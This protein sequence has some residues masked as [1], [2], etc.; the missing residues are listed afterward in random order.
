M[1]K[2]E[3]AGSYVALITPF[4]DNDEVDYAKIEELVEWH[5]AEGT[6]GIVPCGTT[7]ESPTLTEEE[8]KKVIETVVKKANKRCH[9]VA[10]AGG[11]CTKKVVAFT[12]WCKEIGAD[13]VLSVI[14][15][16]NK[17]TQ[18]GLY[19]HFKAVADVGIPV[20]LYN[21]PGRCGGG[22]LT[23]ATIAKLYNDCPT[24]CAVKEATGSV[25]FSSEISSVCGIQ[26]FSGD[27]SLTVPLMSI[28]AKGV[29][30]VAANLTPRK[31]ADLC[32]AMKDGDLKKAQQLHSELYK[33]CKAMFCETNPI[34]CK[35]AGA[36]MGKWKNNTRLPMTPMKAENE[37]QLKAALQ[38]A[39][40]L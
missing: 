21:I 5:I 11:N 4:T 9:V 36:M 22:G 23:S 25:D 16:Y 15:Y 37:P 30:S 32:K 19:G 38:A 14:P 24:I 18:D 31:V 17:P 2:F 34:P 27:D 8:N 35:A 12:K 20:M 39:G 40:L 28:G 26:I 33:L 13:C 6:A 7:G 1:A 29:V 3:L 10:G